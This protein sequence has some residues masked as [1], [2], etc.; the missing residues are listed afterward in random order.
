MGKVGNVPHSTDYIFN[1]ELWHESLLR[2][3]KDCSGSGTSTRASSASAVAAAVAAAAEAAGGGAQG[4]GLVG[5]ELKGARLGAEGSVEGVVVDIADV[6]DDGGYETAEEAE[7]LAVGEEDSLPRVS[8]SKTDEANEKSDAPRGSLTSVGAMD[9]QRMAS[10]GMVGMGVAALEDYDDVLKGSAGS[11][12]AA[13]EAGEAGEV[14]EA[15]PTVQHN[16]RHNKRHKRTA[17]SAPLVPGSSSS[18]REGSSAGAQYSA[19]AST[20]GGAALSALRLS[21]GGRLTTLPVHLR[22]K[23]KS[24]GDSDAESPSG[25]RPLGFM[26]IN[27]RRPLGLTTFRCACSIG[28]DSTLDEAYLTLRRKLSKLLE[29]PQATVR[30]MVQG[31][32]YWFSDASSASILEQV[33][34]IDRE[35]QG[36]ARAVRF[37]DGKGEKAVPAAICVLEPYVGHVRSSADVEANVGA[38]QAVGRAVTCTWLF[39]HDVIDGWRVLRYLCPCILE[40]CPLT[41]ERLKQKHEAGKRKAASRSTTAKLAHTS[42]TL[43]GAV[44]VSPYA[45]YRLARLG[46]A[47]PPLGPRR[48][49]YLHATVSLKKL[50]EIAAT[51]KIGSPST[52]LTACI[53]A[54]FFAA[55]PTRDRCVVGS[56]VLFDPDAPAGNHVC[57]K[58]A[59]L[60]RPQFS[61]R[62]VLT[63]AA[64]TLNA[65]SQS[66]VDLLVGNVTRSFVKGRL[67][68]MVAR[69]IERSHS[70]MDFLVSNLPAFDSASPNV[71]DLQTLRE[72]SE[73]T[74]SIVYVIGVGDE[75]YCDFYWRV[76]S[77]FSTDAFMR[78]FTSVSGAY[79]VHTQLADSY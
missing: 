69:A 52:T 5:V 14:G 77:S 42:K 43:C 11:A 24:M 40:E 38:G 48:Q 4:A 47:S 59:S 56:N 65:S 15:S 44:A 72:C 57:V 71:F 27:F 54:A 49:F 61:D 45:L 68:H 20:I 67:P 78:T 32:R 79:H 33:L 23:A 53:A 7:S 39:R 60:D 18:S 62:S 63:R 2:D 66:L 22:D 36:L 28:L 26:G 75:L 21:G 51:H 16:K 74:P 19:G 73:W 30:L 76:P 6:S 58:M 37:S 41:F 17:S 55:D 8:S 70:A 9:A 64:R 35:G 31:E 13:G 46:F 25:S 34:I 10:N 3:A 29:D 50:K 1:V 12:G